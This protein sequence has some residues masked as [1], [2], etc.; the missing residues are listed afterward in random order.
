MRSRHLSPGHWKGTPVHSGR[1]WGILWYSRVAVK[2]LGERRRTKQRVRESRLPASEKE[3]QFPVE[4]Q[5]GGR[6]LLLQHH[7]EELHQSRSRRTDLQPTHGPEIRDR[8][9][10]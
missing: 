7:K 9:A 1:R 6:L 3:S 10:N 8:E 5:Q 4:V 2:I